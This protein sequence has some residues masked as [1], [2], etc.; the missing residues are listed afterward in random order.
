MI[1]LIYEP[2][3]EQREYTVDRVEMTKECEGHISEYV[4]AFGTFLRAC[5]FMEGT[6]E[7]VLPTLDDDV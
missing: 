4:T 3:E 5:G 6:I 1:K 7:K 2:I